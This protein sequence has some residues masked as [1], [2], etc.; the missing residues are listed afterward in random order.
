MKPVLSA[1]I[2]GFIFAIGLGISG[3]TD[4]NK[5]IGFLE[6]RAIGTRA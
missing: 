6:Y 4:A 1:F 5:V 3:M 2:G